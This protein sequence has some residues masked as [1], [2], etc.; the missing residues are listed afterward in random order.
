MRSRCSPS[1][2][3][4]GTVRLNTITSR[5]SM[6]RATSVTEGERGKV[7]MSVR[8]R[9]RVRFRAS[10]PSMRMG[11]TCC[12]VAVSHTLSTL[13]VPPARRNL[14]P[15]TQAT[16]RMS[17]GSMPSRG[18]KTLAGSRRGDG[19]AVT[20][21]NCRLPSL[22]ATASADP[23]GENSRAR[24]DSKPTGKTPSGST[25][26]CWWSSHSFASRSKSFQ[27]QTSAHASDPTASMVPRG[28]QE[29]DTTA[30]LGLHTS[31]AGCTTAGMREV[32]VLR[33][34]QTRVVVSSLT[35][36]RKVPSGENITSRIVS[37]WPRSS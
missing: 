8:S 4:G 28:L 31:T 11:A 25:T 26:R 2:P 1:A 19:C 13:S 23:S 21:K 6:L 16:A 9:W 27:M 30:L 12:R 22:T 14:P 10:T 32:L 24:T 33:I 37:V 7:S 17:W 18:M 3:A 5:S 20:G 29:R 15:A 34:G 36:A 35:E